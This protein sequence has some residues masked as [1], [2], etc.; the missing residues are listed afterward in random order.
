MSKHFDITLKI[1]QW[2]IGSSNDFDS[3]ERRTGNVV[4]SLVGTGQGTS[5][6]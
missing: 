2:D 1:Y 3:M 4:N 5:V 6:P